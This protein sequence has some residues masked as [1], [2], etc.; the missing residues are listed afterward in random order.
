MTYVSQSNA[1][2]LLVDACHMSPGMPSGDKVIPEVATCDTSCSHF[3]FFL[4][5][6]GLSC[7]LS[8]IS[9]QDTLF[10]FFCFV[11]YKLI[12]VPLLVRTMYAN[13]DWF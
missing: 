7:F 6:G 2:F 4:F 11:L 12:L 9:T 10:F 5:L 1:A 3:L 8:Y 13:T